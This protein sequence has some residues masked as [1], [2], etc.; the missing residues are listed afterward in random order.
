V[1]A[2]LNRH[3]PVLRDG[4]WL[5]HHRQ[6][7]PQIDRYPALV[8]I[9]TTIADYLDVYWPIEREIRTV[10]RRPEQERLYRRLH[11]SLTWVGD[12][13]VTWKLIDELVVVIFEAIIARSIEFAPALEDMRISGT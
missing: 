9:L 1:T 8:R 13:T 2:A 11:A 12:R 10:H 6:S 5:G 7:H 4:L 3:A